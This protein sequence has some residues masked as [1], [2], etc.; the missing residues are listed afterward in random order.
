MGR[1]T[2]CCDFATL[3]KMKD[4]ILPVISQIFYAW[5]LQELKSRYSGIIHYLWLTHCEYERCTGIFY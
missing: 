1:D 5:Y 3:L 4:E 2:K